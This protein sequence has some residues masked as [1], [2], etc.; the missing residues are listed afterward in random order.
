MEQT[1]PKLV[2][3]R[4]QRVLDVVNEVAHKRSGRFEGTVG[5]VLVEEENAQLEGYLTG[6]LGNNILVHFPG[7]KALIGKLINVQLKEAKGFYYI[8]EQV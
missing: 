3:E 7:D 4:F 8:G 2:N 1:D 6:R 5:E